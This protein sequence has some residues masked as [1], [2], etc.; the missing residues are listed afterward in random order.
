MINFG[1]G[2]IIFGLGWIKRSDSFVFLAILVLERNLGHDFIFEFYDN[3]RNKLVII[4]KLSSNH[5]STIL[6]YFKILK[7]I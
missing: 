7:I 1:I 2:S 6:N 5:E 3:V 4:L